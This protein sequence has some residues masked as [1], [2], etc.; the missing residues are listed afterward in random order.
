[1]MD[2][3]NLNLYAKTDPSNMLRRIGELPQ[4]CRDAW[5]SAAKLD[6]PSDYAKVE[7]VIILGMGGS[8]IGGD[9]ASSLAIEQG[10]M[11]ILVQRDYNLPASVNKKTLVI[12]SS[13]SGNTEETL[14]A[15]GQALKTRA[16]KL[17][18]TTGGQLKALAE[19]NGIPLFT[20]K[21]LA[22]PRAALGYSLFSIL[23]IL[24][25]LG[26]LQLSDS[27]VAQAISTLDELSPRL[28]KNMPSISNPA[29]QLAARLFDRL[30][31]IYGAGILSKVALR[32]KT[33]FNEN[34]KAWAFAEYL[35]ELDHNSVVG[36]NFPE[37][38]RQKALVVMLNSPSLHPRIRA[39]FQ[40]TAEI[41]TRA[42]IE[43]ETVEAQG[44]TLLA[45]MM[46]TIF[47]GDYV[48][49]YLAIL[50]R[51]DPAPVATIDYLK[52]RLGKLEA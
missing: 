46:S 48:S 13:Y 17:A 49:Y 51:T 7:K 38:L 34:S 50:N 42:G 36:Y 29:K 47:L 15:F 23:G 52:Q 6:L 9:L 37:W 3:D 12:A 40:I 30:A 22:E 20:F 8:A 31:V 11:P 27:D 14:S 21:Y 43:H 33:Q 5:Q 39:R 28:D 26:L 35:P 41:M 18:I 2:L 1:M 32:W 16:R 19:Q 25:K 4:Q 10:A 44:A 45:Q 24:Q